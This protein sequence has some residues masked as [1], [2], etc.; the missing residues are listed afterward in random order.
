MPLDSIRHQSYAKNSISGSTN[1]LNKAANNFPTPSFLE[2]T[3]SYP[4]SSLYSP[5]GSTPSGSFHS[6]NFSFCLL[7]VKIFAIIIGLGAIGCSWSSATVVQEDSGS[8]SS[9]N[10]PETTIRLLVKANADK[11]LETMKQYM[12]TDENVIGYTIG[13]RKYV[14]WDGFAQ[15]MSLE[16]ASVDRLEIPIPYLEVW[17]REDV[18]WFAMELDYTR[19]VTN[20]K[21]QVEKTVI[22]LRETGVLERRD[23]TW[24]IVNWHESLRKPTQTVSRTI[25]NSNTAIPGVPLHYPDS[26]DL[27]GEW[28]IQEEDKS[29]RATLDEKGNGSYTWQD[30]TLTTSKVSDGLW[31]GKWAQN[32]NDREG[33]FEVLLSEDMKTAQG[34][35]WYTRVGEHQNIPPRE[36]GGSYIF[37]RL[38]S[39]PADQNPEP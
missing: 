23:G 18:A 27:S 21:G 15:T 16:F 34:V 29:Y 11:D 31:A 28:E 26:V 39:S 12:G 30:G 4:R 20:D 9:P 3:I 35:W 7:L 13:G 38:I 37:K 32:G 24:M 22:P 1:R 19:E 33:E 36:W 14:G 8:P 17:Q 25:P 10:D 2:P 5:R 6:F